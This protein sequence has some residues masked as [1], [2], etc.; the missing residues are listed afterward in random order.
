MT[1]ELLGRNK[2]KATKQVNGIRF[3]RKILFARLP[4]KSDTMSGL[5]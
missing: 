5:T 4:R 2:S 1:T 3:E